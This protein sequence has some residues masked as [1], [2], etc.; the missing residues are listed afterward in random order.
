MKNLLTVFVLVMGAALLAPFSAAHGKQTP[1][2]VAG[3]WHFVLDTPG[4]DRPLDA[5]FKVDGDQVSGKWATADVKGT[6]SDSKL[7]LEFTFNSEEA[8]SGTM[9]IDGA[10]AD[11]VITGNWA[12]SEYAGTFKATRA[13]E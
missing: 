13:K 4:G 7:K 2:N 9:K 12:F 11:D 1:A 8:G 5:E 3:K 10:L 6:F